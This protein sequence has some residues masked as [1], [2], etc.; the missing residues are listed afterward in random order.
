MA[1]MPI[2][3]VLNKTFA[4]ANMANV[5]L[6]KGRHASQKDYGTPALAR[7]L[8]KSRE[9]V[10]EFLTAE[11]IAKI[12]RTSVWFVYQHRKLF[13]GLKIGGV[14]RF[15][16]EIFETK[17]KEVMKIDSIS[18]PCE[19]EIRLLEERDSAQGKRLSDQT[20]SQG[21]RGRSPKKSKVDEFGLYKLMRQPPKGA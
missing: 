4:L 5:P 8:G 7:G 3:R 6:A 10:M 13:G 20:G 11:E 16:K 9:V 1:V 12:L 21:R 17:V 18:A 15:D 14:V 19:M 2:S